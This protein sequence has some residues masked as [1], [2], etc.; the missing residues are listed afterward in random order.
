MMSAA[1]TCITLG[2]AAG[3]R[4][5]DFS[6]YEKNQVKFEIS[7]PTT[8]ETFNRLSVISYSTHL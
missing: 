4:T 8:I 6:I 2:I 7:K 3:E 5:C 1:T